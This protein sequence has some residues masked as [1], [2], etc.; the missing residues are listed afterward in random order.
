MSKGAATGTEV[1]PDEV[2]AAWRSTP[3]PTLRKLEQAFAAQGRKAGRTYIAKCLQAGGPIEAQVVDLSAQAETV[4]AQAV[5]LERRAEAAIGLEGLSHS[6]ARRS[7][8][9]SASALV[10][11]PS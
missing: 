8:A 3:N 9:A 6:A 7:I 4:L 11:R 5:E 10:I 2:R 1:P